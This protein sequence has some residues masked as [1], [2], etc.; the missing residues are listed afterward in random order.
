LGDQPS[1]IANTGFEVQNPTAWTNTS[2][3]VKLNR[4][5][6]TTA[7]NKYLFVIDQYGFVNDTGFLITGSTVDTSSPTITVGPT[8]SPITATSGTVLWTTDE[9]TTSQVYWGVTTALGNQT[10]FDGTFSVGHVVPLTNLQAASTYY[11]RVRSQDAANLVVMSATASFVT[12]PPP[13][14]TAPLISGTTAI[15]VQMDGATIVWYTDEPATR[16]VNYGL[17]TSYGSSTTL[18][19]NFTTTHTVQ[20]S[21]LSN[22]T[23]YHFRVRSADS[24]N[25]ERVSGN[26]TFTTT[27][28]ITTTTLVLSNIAATV[29]TNDAV[30]TW[31]TNEPSSSLVEYGLTGA[32]GDSLGG[33][34]FVPVT[35]HSISLSGLSSGT[36]YHYR[37][38]SV[39]P[40]GETVESEI[41]TFTTDT[42]AAGSV[43]GNLGAR[44]R[45]QKSGSRK[46]GF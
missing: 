25:N 24:T 5:R 7:L 42:V 1:Y 28:E 45:Q 22:G 41:L 14:V 20:L 8:V 10:T 43:Q 18:Q 27:A 12:S 46:R 35:S 6:F 29:G 21:G 30:I 33:D 32:L 36:L 34:I 11:Y 3:S 31:D 13:D 40:S 16:R 15:N 38:I 26:F 4:G 9:E 44:P 17:T 39:D 2:I 19:S 37:V 23:T